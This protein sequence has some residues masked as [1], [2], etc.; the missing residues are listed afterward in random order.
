MRKIVLQV[1][2][3]LDGYIEGPNEEFDWCFSDQDYGMTNFM[4]RVDAMF[5]GRKSYELVQRMDNE[6]NNKFAHLKMYVF[7]KTLNEVKDGVTI[8][9]GDIKTEVDQ[10]CKQPGK[11][12]WLFGGTS[13]TT[14]LLSLNLIHE[15][16]LAVHPILLGG[17]KR[18]FPEIGRRIPLNL[19]SAK[20][21]TSGL[22]MLTYHL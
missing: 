7:T 1:A 3:S 14:S 5:I 22:T 20:P 11:D 8:I 9:S 6:A 4:K 13:L 10:I 21:Y 18:L 12:I 19:V 16:I 15:M 17:G 2:I